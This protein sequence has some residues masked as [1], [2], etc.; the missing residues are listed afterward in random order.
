MKF[1]IN[2]GKQTAFTPS[3]R[4]I[5]TLHHDA[6]RLY[7]PACGSGEIEDITDIEKMENGAVYMTY[8]IPLV[9]P[10]IL[11]DYRCCKCGHKW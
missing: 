1:D 8:G 4:H 9:I 11:F 2:H 6:T 7:C 10:D 5:T 3:Y